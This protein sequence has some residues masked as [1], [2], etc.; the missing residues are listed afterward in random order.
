MAM[1]ANLDTPSAAGIEARLDLSSLPEAQRVAFYGAMFAIAAIDGTWGQDELEVIFQTIHTAGLSE[2]SRTTLWEYLVEPPDLTDCLVGFAASAEGVRCAVMLYLIEVALADRILATSEDEALLQAR[3]CLHISQKQIEAIEH[4]ICNVG[5]VRAR[6]RDYHGEA[7]DWKCHYGMWLVAGL[8][9]P[10][11]TVYLS[12]LLGGVSVVEMLMALP[13]SAARW[14]LLCGAGVTAMIGATVVLSGR[15][16]YA[17]Y[18][19]R[20]LPVTVE[21][22]RLARTCLSNLQ[23]AVSYLTA[24]ASLHAVV[25]DPREPGIESPL[26]FS[27]CLWQ[28]QQMLTR[29]QPNVAAVSTVSPEV[30]R[31]SSR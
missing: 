17:R 9:L 31:L 27:N 28:L 25:E 8:G 11:V 2:R 1:S 6:L 5:L 29:R 20:R 13:S 14:P 30:P 3:T 22:R 19:R 24:K 15:S 26:L 10:T 4:Y 23:D 18:Q 7:I 21:R 12:S 16:L